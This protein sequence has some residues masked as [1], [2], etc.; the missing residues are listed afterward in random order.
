MQRWQHEIV[1]DTLALV[2]CEISELGF[3]WLKIEVPINKCPMAFWWNEVQNT[4]PTK[5]Y[6]PLY[7]CIYRKRTPPPS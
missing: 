1:G 5:L 4:T 2:D 6:L 3:N 7:D